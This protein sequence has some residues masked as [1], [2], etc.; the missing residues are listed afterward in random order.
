MKPDVL[1]VVLTV[2]MILA[3]SIPIAVADNQITIPEQDNELLQPLA[4]W[5]YTI[6]LT[7]RDFCVADDGTVFAVNIQ[8]GWDLIRRPSIPSSFVAF[9]VTGELLWIKNYFMH[10]L[11]LFGVTTDDT[12]VFVT[13]FS[14]EGLFVGKY[15]FD[16]NSI[17][18]YTR[19]FGEL[20]CG[21][22]ISVSEG[23]YIIVRTSFPDQ[24]SNTFVDAYLVVLNPDG[25]YLWHKS[26]Q[27]FAFA[28]CDSSFIYIMQDRVLE[29]YEMDGNLI[30]SVSITEERRLTAH[31]DILFSCQTDDFGEIHKSILT[32]EGWNPHTGGRSW[33]STLTLYDTA[34]EVFN[35]TS[36][37]CSSAQDDSLVLLLAGPWD[38]A[39]RWHLL[40]IDNQGHPTRYSLVLDTSWRYALCEPTDTG[41]LIVV[42]DNSE[43]DFSVAVFDPIGPEPLYNLTSSESLD[44]FLIGITVIG[45]VVFD[46][47]LIIVLRKKYAKT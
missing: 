30:W 32:I 12:H 23:G 26:F 29:K 20:G 24:F 46:S 45:V 22:R 43:T 8:N 34:N 28:D 10:E 27:D 9:S 21:L 36:V 16:G 2:F 6:S 41:Q 11:A 39:N 44:Y 25:E 15:D 1:K 33:I 47:S 37:D 13:G 38:S 14:L 19:D 35:L 3:S 7:P 4:F 31:N 5:N 17:W 40:M 18:N 42:G